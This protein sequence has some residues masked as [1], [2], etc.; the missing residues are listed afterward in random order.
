[1]R[2]SLKQL[3]YSAHRNV[4]AVPKTTKV[5]FNINIQY[6]VPDNLALL[7]V[8]TDVIIGSIFSMNTEADVYLLATLFPTM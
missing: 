1:M 7:P 2:N 5:M 3:F 8:V 4:K 6:K